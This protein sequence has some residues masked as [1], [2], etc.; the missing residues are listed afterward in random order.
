MQ[1]C[2][3]G[4]DAVDAALVH[5][6]PAWPAA[7]EGDVSCQ[8]GVDED[9]L[10]MARDMLQH[11]TQQSGQTE[12]QQDA[13][14]AE[15]PQAP[16]EP[17]PSD[18]DLVQ[19]MLDARAPAANIQAML[20]QPEKV[21]PQ[22]MMGPRQA[23][24]TMGDNF[25]NRLAERYFHAVGLMLDPA[26]GRKSVKAVLHHFV[27][28]PVHKSLSVVA[29]TIDSTPKLVLQTLLQLAC[30][31]LWATVFLVGA[32]LHAW[33]VLFRF[34]YYRPVCIINKFKYDETPLKMRV[35]EF[36]RIFNRG[37]AP[38]GSKADA[39]QEY[40]HAKILRVDWCLGVLPA[41]RS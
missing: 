3:S 10:Q 20:Q 4:S 18:L 22:D 41:S 16:P 25:Q 19:E 11:H 29:D 31:L 24:A 17:E 15:M 34:R 32:F 40:S 21:Q 39:A 12:S 38:S 36:N 27:M 28:S 9:V 13:A 30:A 8:Q 1:P 2:S 5:V 35:A 7:A 37:K 33:T 6:G 14:D 23:L 26:R